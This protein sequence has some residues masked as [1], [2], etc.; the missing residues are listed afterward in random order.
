MA[1][2]EQFGLVA[3]VPKH[4]I[5][6]RTRIETTIESIIGPVE[7]DPLNLAKAPVEFQAFDTGESVIY[8][9]QLSHPELFGETF[10]VLHENAMPI[11]EDNKRLSTLGIIDDW[12]LLNRDSKQNRQL[13][14]LHTQNLEPYWSEFTTTSLPKFLHAISG[15][16]AE[17]KTNYLQKKVGKLVTKNSAVKLLPELI[18]GTLHDQNSYAVLMSFISPARRILSEN[19]RAAPSREKQDAAPKDKIQNPQVSRKYPEVSAFEVL[20]SEQ[21]TLLVDKGLLYQYMNVVD[22]MQGPSEI[23]YLKDFYQSIISEA[24]LVPITESSLDESI[25]YEGNEFVTVNLN[26]SFITGRL[27]DRGFTELDRHITADNQRILSPWIIWEKD[28]VTG[29]RTYLSSNIRDDIQ[30]VV[31]SKAEPILGLVALSYFSPEERVRLPKEVTIGGKTQEMLEA[32]TPLLLSMHRERFLRGG[33]I[34]KFEQ[35]AEE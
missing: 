29:R 20:N 34:A 2:A 25:S 13:L 21:K 27:T 32:Q 14:H 5:L 28:K 1:K 7:N 15:L 23:P 11:R 31:D 26:G 4:R 24:E 16:S 33:V 35:L 10:R 6:E 9:A 18:A 30:S 8:S 22:T 3:N 17:Q 19:K 12:E